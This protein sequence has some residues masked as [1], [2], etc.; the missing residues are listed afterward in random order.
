MVQSNGTRKSNFPAQTSVPGDATFDYVSNG[1]NYKIT[2]ANLIN[3]LGVV[4]SIAQVGDA[5][6]TPVLDDQGLVKGIRNIKAGF[7]LSAG[8]AGDNSLEIETNFSFG[9][10]GVDL[11][12]DPASDAPEF[13]SITVG[14]GISVTSS[15]DDIK[16]TN[17]LP[18]PV[19]QVMV[20]ELADFP[21]PVGDVI[22]LLDDTCYRI[23][24]SV[25][26]AGNRFATGTNTILCGSSS[27]IDRVTTTSTGAL[28]TGTGTITVQGVSLDIPNGTIFNMSGTGVENL[29]T[30]NIRTVSALSLGT[31]T[32]WGLTVIA[33]SGLFGLSAGGLS[34]VGSHGRFSITEATVVNAAGTG[35]DLGAATFDTVYIGTNA[36]MVAA[37]GATCLEIAPNSA[38]INAGG[39]G[40]VL[41]NAF[42]GAG[43]HITGA[44]SGDLL[45]E[46]KANQ[47][48]TDTL[49]SAQGYIK[50][51]ALTTV[52]G[53]INTPVI[54]NFGT[55][56]IADIQDR[57]TIDNTGRFTYI[58]E[59]DI[60]ILLDATIFARISG[61]A[62]RTYNY[63][64][65]KNDTIIASSIASAEYDG[66]NPGSNSVTSLV[67][68]T[69]NDYIEIWV[70]AAT[71]VTV[72]NVENTSLK[73]RAQ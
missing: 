19:N 24:N 51:S 42:R 59:D 17:T 18:A 11:V 46:R 69:K 61:G 47:G 62:A 36:T 15:T 50:G 28:I 52:F 72:L 30:R 66:A 13:R 29:I 8:I 40:V 57:F 38:N 71:A 37:A 34:F 5:L 3:S 7:G 4:G 64:A 12:N 26:I 54:V 53:A 20:A 41:G 73:V 1:V 21:D 9:G 45:W 58:G 39:R 63:Y 14:R 23:S 32:D 60:E 67:D 33:E 35:I 10:A 25:D 16:I 56:F 48:I 55:A 22:S 68:L 31:L 6:D 27:L 43:T 49:S 70:E 2:I 44:D 65:T